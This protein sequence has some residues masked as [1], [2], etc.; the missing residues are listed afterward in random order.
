MRLKVSGFFVTGGSLKF[1]IS[2]LGQRIIFFFFIR[3]KV[4]SF[5][6]FKN[7][8]RYILFTVTVNDYLNTFAVLNFF[9]PVYVFA[10]FSFSLVFKD[11]IFKKISLFYNLRVTIIYSVS[12]SFIILKVFISY[13]RFVFA[14]AFFFSLPKSRIVIVLALRNAAAFSL[15]LTAPFTLT[16]SIVFT[17]FIAQFSFLHIAFTVIPSFRIRLFL[18]PSPLPPSAFIAAI[19]SPYSRSNSPKPVFILTQKSFIFCNLIY[20]IG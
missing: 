7:R 12:G 19:Y 5:S 14:A 3:L 16:V 20:S 18:S 8:V 4:V 13:K 9:L 17:A 11:V 10:F 15:T 1:T 2:S 6:A